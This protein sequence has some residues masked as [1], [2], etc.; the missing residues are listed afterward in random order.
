M[1]GA[2]MWGPTW[3]TASGG[4]GGG[5][6]VVA[7]IGGDFWYD[8]SQGRYFTPG[9]L[10]SGGTTTSWISRFQSGTLVP[11]TGFGPTYGSGTYSLPN[12]YYVGTNAQSPTVANVSMFIANTATSTFYGTLTSDSTNSGLTATLTTTTAPSGS[13][14]VVGAGLKGT[15][16]QTGMYVVKN[17]TGTPTG[18]GS[19]WQVT[20]P[21]GT[22]ANTVANTAL[23]LTTTTANV[24]AVASGIVGVG[25]YIYKS[26]GITTNTYIT[27]S[28]AEN[29][30]LTGTGGTGTYLVNIP[31][32]QGTSAAPVSGYTLQVPFVGF[33]SG[34]AFR[35]PM[36][37]NDRIT[38][39][40]T[41]FLA[42]KFGTTTGTVS[43][44]GSTH[45]NGGD[46][47]FTN[48]AGTWTYNMA[49]AT[50]TGSS[51]DT[52][53]NIHT[54]VYDGTQTGNANRY[55]VYINGNI[56]TLTFTGTVLGNTAPPAT[57]SSTVTAASY[58]SVTD[59]MVLT[60]A[61]TGSPAYE[62]GDSITVA[63]LSPATTSDSV[64][65]NGT[66]SVVACNNTSVTYTVTSSGTYTRTSGGTVVGVPI[67]NLMVA[68]KAPIASATK[69]TNPVTATQG[70]NIGELIVYSKALDDVTRQNTEKYLR[71][72]WLGTN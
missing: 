69:N 52:K 61:T 13:G 4:G 54:L 51:V 19:T 25:D 23:T 49:N 36:V 30:S 22:Y 32:A 10:A 43:A 34:D 50:A 42:C 31:Q 59:R 28:S 47:S 64:N 2:I 27:A 9:N 48:S 53:W 41:L 5:S 33:N 35:V 15:G 17:L 44:C 66:F 46:Y 72:K 39:S 1:S 6:G 8:A 21:I 70:I 45:G 68:G 7:T 16:V 24:T 37:G 12:F 57:I 20:V 18:V 11:T 62:V 67:P 58:S 63:G 55:K 29:S 38:T 3:T 40:Y 26:T 65:V 60:Y 14:I 56:Q 71:K